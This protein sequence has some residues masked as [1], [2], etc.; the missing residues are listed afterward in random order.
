MN[1]KKILKKIKLAESS[2]SSF[3]GFLVVII[4]G[5][6]IFKYFQGA[7]KPNLPFGNQ[8]IPAESSE[9]LANP[10]AEVKNHNV[11][12]GD[13]L[14]S[15]AEKY[16]GSGY[17]WVDIANENN[18]V[19]PDVLIIGSELIIP[20]VEKRMATIIDPQP[21]VI[22]G[23][24]YTVVK[25]DNLWSIAVRAYGDGYRWTELAKANNLQNPGVIHPGNVFIIP[26]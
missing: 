23:D 1:L 11:Q 19:N 17:N 2:I 18:L 6:L 20:V 13:S 4:V 12:E 26:R 7:G 24:R 9:S 14:W 10:T 22:S 5:A 8:E 21:V 16:Y 25:G 15:I 3:F